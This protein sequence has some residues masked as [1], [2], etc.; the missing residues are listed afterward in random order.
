MCGKET[1]L[2]TALIESAE[3][4]V[5]IN[6]ARFGNVLKKPVIKEKIKSAK[7][8]KEI[9]ESII[10][11]YN[12]VIKSARERLGLTQEDFAKKVNERESVIAQFESG[13]LKP[14]I[15]IARKLEKLLNINLVEELE[16]THNK[17]AGIKSE[18]LTLGDI[19][20]L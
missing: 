7:P 2:V 20:K 9:I 10:P 19:I 18:G 4:K 15:I 12:K 5:C 13:H 17:T 3:L 11:D 8:E 6:C 16:I 1:E 14:T